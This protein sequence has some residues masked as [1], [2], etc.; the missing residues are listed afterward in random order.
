MAQLLVHDTEDIGH[1]VLALRPLAE[2]ILIT[3]LRLELHGRHAGALLATV[4]LLLHHQ[5]ELVEAVHPC[6]ILLLVVLQRFQQANHGHA[7]I[8][9]YVILHISCSRPP[10]RRRAYLDIIAFLLFHRHALGQVARQ[11]HILAFADSDIVGQ[12]LQGERWP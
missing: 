8:L 9:V 1:G 12:Q 3:R 2:H 7:T 10:R 5:I 4:V 11:V 6:T